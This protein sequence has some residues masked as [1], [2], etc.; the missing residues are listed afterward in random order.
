MQI[1]LLDKH[2]EIGGVATYL[3]TLT[4]GLVKKGYSV[5]LLT[6]ENHENKN[7]LE[8]FEDAGITVKTIPCHKNKILTLYRFIQGI[9]QL[10]KKNRF[11]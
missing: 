1:L 11:I 10:F 6:T 7:I 9:R 8:Q 3:E 5:Y 2:L 4:D